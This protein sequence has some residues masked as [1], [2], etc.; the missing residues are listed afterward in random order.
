M[1]K[2]PPAV[3]IL[4]ME[5]RR[6]D[7]LPKWLSTA[8]CKA[9][10]MLKNLVRHIDNVL[11]QVWLPTTD[12]DGKTTLQTRGAPYIIVGTDDSVR[13]GGWE[14]GFPPPFLCAFAGNGWNHAYGRGCLS[15][16]MCAFFLAGYGLA[17]LPRVRVENIIG[18][19]VG[20]SF[21]R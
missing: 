3:A 16:I 2:M 11:V 13:T 18:K 21:Q 15:S 20:Y 10:M 19:V 12:V 9:V 14:R 4:S 5:V 7:D 1:H 8:L 6:E 17:S